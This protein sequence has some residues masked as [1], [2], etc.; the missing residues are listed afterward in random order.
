MPELVE[1]SLVV[2]LGDPELAPGAGA[3]LHTKVGGLPVSPVPE[4]S[5]KWW[6]ISMTLCF[7]GVVLIFILTL[8]P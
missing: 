4:T 5:L 3:G 1:T 8:T 7:V 6:E 2:G